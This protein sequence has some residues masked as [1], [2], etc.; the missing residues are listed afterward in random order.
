M[1]VSFFIYSTRDFVLLL[2]TK[3]TCLPGGM[4]K[5]RPLLGRR[6]LPLLRSISRTSTVPSNK[7]SPDHKTPILLTSSAIVQA[8]RRK[9]V[10]IMVMAM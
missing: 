9:N 8:Y 3:T 4:V 1:L 10:P 7:W 2:V 6:Y 5:E